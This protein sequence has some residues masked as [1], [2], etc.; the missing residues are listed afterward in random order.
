MFPACNLRK[1]VTQVVGEEHGIGSPEK[2]RGAPVPPSGKKTP[3][4][5]ESGAGPAIEAAFDRH[6]G[7][8]FGGD[9][10][11]RDAPEERDDQEIE[12]GHT[13]AAGGDH[14]FEA[15]GASCGVRKHDEHEVKKAGLADE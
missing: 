6:G 10:R 8:E 15:E 13:R 12:Q 4:I 11:Y 1:I 2:E 14:A 3:E 7:G 5:T 9:Q